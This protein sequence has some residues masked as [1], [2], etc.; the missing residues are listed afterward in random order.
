MNIDICNENLFN[1]AYF[2]KGLGIGSN[3]AL[4]SREDQIMYIIPINQNEK[5]ITISYTKV[6]TGSRPYAF[7]N[8]IPVDVNSKIYD[9]GYTANQDDIGK[10]V[11]TVINNNYKYLHIIYT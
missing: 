8:S 7:A 6:N 10:R 11:K 1:Q 9:F 2:I 5:N 3:G 4:F